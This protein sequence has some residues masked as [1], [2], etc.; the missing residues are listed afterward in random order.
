M[1]PEIDCQ[2]P[3]DYSSCGT[4]TARVTVRNCKRL[5]WLDWLG[6]SLSLSYVFSTQKTS[7][8][9]IQQT[10]FFSCRNV[11]TLY[12]AEKNFIQTVYLLCS[13]FQVHKQLFKLPSHV[14]S[15][16]F[17]W[18]YGGVTSGSASLI[19]FKEQNKVSFFFC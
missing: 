17:G 13:S 8:F 9:I 6:K 4:S 11:S 7:S 15:L 5:I 1:R 10:H 18:C 3:K 12:Y 2:R 14:F 19:T 16:M